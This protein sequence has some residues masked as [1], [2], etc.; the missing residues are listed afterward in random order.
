MSYQEMILSD[1]SRQKVVERLQAEPKLVQDP[2]KQNWFYHIDD[3]SICLRVCFENPAVKKWQPT[4]CLI[5]YHDF[6]GGDYRVSKEGLYLYC[7]IKRHFGN[8][9]I[10]SLDLDID[11][12][13][14]EPLGLKT[15]KNQKTA[16]AVTERPIFTQVLESHYRCSEKRL[17]FQNRYMGIG[18]EPLTSTTIDTILR[19]NPDLVTLDMD[20]PKD[21]LEFLKEIYNNPRWKQVSD[22]VNIVTFC[23]YSRSDMVSIARKIYGKTEQEKHPFFNEVPYI[24]LPMGKG[25]EVIAILD[26][27]LRQRLL[28]SWIRNIRSYAA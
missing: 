18:S 5:D 16:L 14:E 9:R 22:T 27:F 10:V 8:R 12:S 17:P 15:K 7:R 11:P 6:T 26:H 3:P 13:T 1:V 2:T 4:G 21:G 20:D 25:K 23:L 24:M 19:E 28:M